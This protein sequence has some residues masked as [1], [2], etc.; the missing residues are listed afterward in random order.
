VGGGARGAGPARG[1]S[2][3]SGEGGTPE[4]HGG[5]LL[6][7]SGRLQRRRRRCCAGTA[8]VLPDARQ[9]GREA[10][11]S[12][13]GV[14]G[15]IRS[16]GGATVWR[17]HLGALGSGMGT[18]ASAWYHA[19]AHAVGTAPSGP[20]GGRRAAHS[21]AA[22][23]RTDDRWSGA[24]VGIGDRTGRILC[25]RRRRRCDPNRLSQV[26]LFKWAGR[27]ATVAA[28]PAD[29]LGGSVSPFSHT[30]R[31]RLCCDGPAPL[32]IALALGGMFCSGLAAN[33]FT[34][35]IGSWIASMS[36]L[37]YL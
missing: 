29:R 13:A 23:H 5:R 32:R 18:R 4:H 33:K 35:T 6:Q 37:T 19:S 14:V 30:R 24:G 21:L 15:A 10:R 9:H 20:H 27:D 1:G 16:T 36:N 8:G 22:A 25:G 26:C 31:M 3:S 2:G 17:T 34:G 7:P 12:S 28:R 11:G